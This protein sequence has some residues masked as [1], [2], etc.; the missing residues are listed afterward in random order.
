MEQI[1]Y[2]HDT[3]TRPMCTKRNICT[4]KFLLTLIK[5]TIKLQNNLSTTRQKIGKSPGKYDINRSFNNNNYF[6]IRN[7]ASS[8]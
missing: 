6:H 2:V 1:Q 7:T 3:T 8:L 5:H 4:F